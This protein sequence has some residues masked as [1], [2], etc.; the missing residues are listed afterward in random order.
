MKKKFYFLL[1]LMLGCVGLMCAQTYVEPQVGKIYY[2]KGKRSQKYLKASGT[3]LSL[4]A[5]KT[6]DCLFYVDTDNKIKAYLTS[7]YIN[8]S[9]KNLSATTSYAGVFTAGT[10][11]AYYYKNNGYYIYGGANT[12]ATNIDRGTS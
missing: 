12:S 7:N 10:D 9:G 3:S 1:A 2:M 5:E 4:S 11:G 8:C 6:T